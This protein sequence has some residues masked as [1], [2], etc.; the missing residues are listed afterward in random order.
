MPIFVSHL[1]KSM[2]QKLFFFFLNPI[3]RE[4]RPLQSVLVP[5]SR[6]KQKMSYV[7]NKAKDNLIYHIKI[8]KFLH[9]YFGSPPAQGI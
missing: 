4:P 3:E 7:I 6:V 2:E 8:L 5:S 9:I 1:S